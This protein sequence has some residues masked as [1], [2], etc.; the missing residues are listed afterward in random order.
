MALLFAAAMFAQ[1]TGGLVPEGNPDIRPYIAISAVGF[2]IGVIGHIV[3]F[4]PLV[5]L[6]ILI[7][8]LG[9]LIIPLIVFSDL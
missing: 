9:V 4:Y 3:R 6:G 5:A 8:T 2:A 1:G 7:V